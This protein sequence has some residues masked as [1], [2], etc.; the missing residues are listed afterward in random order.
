[1]A[2]MAATDGHRVRN[3]PVINRDQ[4][5]ANKIWCKAGKSL[6]LENIEVKIHRA[7]LRAA[8]KPVL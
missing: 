4:V 3:C 6:K 5:Y 8:S 2:M 7:Y 1:M